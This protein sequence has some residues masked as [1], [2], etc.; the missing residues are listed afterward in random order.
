MTTDDGIHRLSAV[1]AGSRIRTGALSPVTLLEA[2][3][4]Q[5]DRRE[6]D[7]GAWVTL[8]RTGALETARRLDDEARHGKFRGALHGIPVGLKDIIHIAGLRTTAGARGFAD[9]A[10][11]RDATAVERLRAAGAVIL[12]KLQTSEFATADP[13][14]TRNP[15]RLDRTPG[16]SSAGSAAAVAARMIPAAL[17]SQTVGSTLRPAAFCGVVGFKPSYGSISRQGIIPV[18]W[19]LDHV[20]LFTRTVADAGMFFSVL[21]AS[22]LKQHPGDSTQAPRIGLVGAP[23]ADRADPVM[24]DHLA[25]IHTRL[26]GHGARIERLDLPEIVRAL[27]AAVTVVMWAEV[28]AVHS[29]LHAAHADQYRPKIRAA[30]EA[31]ACIPAPFYLRAQ[32]IRRAAR[33]VLVPLLQRFDACLMPAAAGPAPDPATTG[34]PSFNAPWSGIGAP[35]IAVPTGL[36]ADGLPLGLQLI[37]AP[38]AE[39]RLLAAARWVEAR[40]GFHE[41]PPGV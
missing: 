21:T 40:I 38:G 35:Q 32:Q 37:G 16:G 30:I 7:V 36:A 6:P 11:N 15:W 33:Q 9:T 29:E 28:A 8:D 20:G 41:T 34:D 26:A 12:G 39:T 17:G 31:G 24:R 5:I 14:S 2:C 19:S 13:A 25:I 10:P 4:R 3:L 22:T 18:A 27:L 1:E 23:F